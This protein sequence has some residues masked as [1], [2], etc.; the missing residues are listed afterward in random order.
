MAGVIFS[1]KAWFWLDWLTW[2]TLADESGRNSRWIK[3]LFYR[4]G[5]THFEDKCESRKCKSLLSSS[6]WQRASG[7]F[8]TKK[9][10]WRVWS[11]LSLNAGGVA[12]T[13]KSHG[14]AR[15]SGERVSNESLMYPGHRDSRSKDRVIPDKITQPHGCVLK[16]LPATVETVCE[17]AILY[18]LV[19]EV[20]A[21]QG[22]DA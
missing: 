17:Q 19:G 7:V 5:R 10:N 16:G 6:E 12:K 15:V 4:F 2:F 9:F 18:Q 1:R 20:T 14:P 21:H 3:S 13:C 11:W 22:N 8:R